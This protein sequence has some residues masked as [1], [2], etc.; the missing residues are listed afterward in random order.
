MLSPDQRSLYTAA[1]APPAG[2]VFDEALATTYS[3][4]LVTLLSIPVHL[5]LVGER[6]A[7]DPLR[8]GI[9]LLEALR[10]YTSRL[11]VY[12]QGGQLQV[13]TGAPHALYGL[14][15]PVVV[16]AAAPR[17][18]A[19]HPKLWVLRFTDAEDPVRV[20]LRLLVLSRNL[21]ADNAWDLVLTLEG[22]PRGRNVAANRSLSEL[23][24]ALPDCA[25]RPVAPPRREQALRLADE[26]RRTTWDLPDGFE[27]VAFHVLGTGRR[28]FDVPDS[29]RLVVISPFVTAGAAQRLV[30]STGE[31]VA[32]VSRTDTLDALPAAT[33]T[34]F[35]RCF[36]LDEAAETEDGEDVARPGAVGLHA[37]ALVLNR[38]WYTHL[39]LGSA[40]ATT[41]A[42][43]AGLNVEVVAELVGKRTRVGT[44]DDV[45]GVKGL[46]DVLVEYAPSDDRPPPDPARLAAEE[47]AA[48][49]RRLLA[50]ARLTL[51]CEPVEGDWELC[52]RA[53]CDI[54]LEGV[55]GLSVWPLTVTE[56]RAIRVASVGQGEVVR[57][58]R[59]PTAL[60]TGF[61]AFAV[62]T[63]VED[64]RARFVLNL[65]VEGLPAEREAA[66]LR[67][68]VRNREGFLR[69]LLLLL[70]ESGGP[71]DLVPALPGNGMSAQRWQCGSWEDMPLL[72]ELARAF[73]RDPA[74]IA[75][76]GRVVVQLT[77]ADGA[78]D[79]VPPEF[80]DLWQ[81]FTA[82]L[83]EGNDPPA[84]V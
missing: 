8:D 28:G 3:L 67:T 37:K 73:S 77:G 69:Y 76:V 18:G 64:V 60:V 9:A 74:R 10:R 2:Y 24:A 72:E 68:V 63:A 30:E 57:L 54:A 70:G 79:V 55:T 31:A 53:P 22:E 27:S 43:E 42:M 59:L 34:R 26:L 83:E 25:I 13:P 81:T 21:T 41:A 52:L 48:R 38:G 29:N 56:D 82:A 66:I 35:G 65:P 61:L 36:V 62:G 4:D 20:R 15:E 39:L 14:L 1:F 12:A 49:I 50:E 11:T 17:G 51:H 58:G 32:L 40:N 44:V 5:A 80:L 6:A 47:A 16:E 71:L 19:F 7:A 33:R 75:D 45:L 78:P 46:Q 84:A 23:L